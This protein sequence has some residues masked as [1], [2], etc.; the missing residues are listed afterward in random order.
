MALNT[1][2][3]PERVQVF[4][5]PLGV[6]Q[7]PGAA[8]SICAFLIS[9]SA[10]GAPVNV[11]TRVTDMA[12]FEDAFGTADDVLYDGYYAVKGYFDNGGTGKTAVIVN[13][14]T[15]PTA[16]SFI[17][18]AS[19]GTGLRA[20]DSQDDIGLV[21]APGLPLSMAY[22]VQPAVIDYSETVRTEFGASLSTVFSLLSVPKEITKANT[23]T[24]VVAAS[25]LA[26]SA[27][28]G[29]VVSLDA[30]DLSNVTPG[31]VV[32]KASTRIATI[33]AVNDSLNTLTLTSVTGLADDDNITVEMPSAVVYKEGVINNPSK[34]AAWYFNPPL[35]PDLSSTASPGDLVTIDPVG[36]IAGIMG[37]IDANIAIGGISHAPAGIQYAGLAGISGLSLTLSERTDAE[38][39]RLNFINRLQSFPGAGNVVF[40]GYTADSGTS[41][42][43]TADEQLIQVMRTVQYIKA[44][45]EPGLRSFLWENFSPDTQTQVERAIEAFLTNNIH[46]FPAGLPQAQQFRVLRV[47][48]TQ[49]DLDLGLLKVRVLV[50]PNKAVRFIEVSLEFPLQS[51]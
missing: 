3:G 19:T 29:L 44:S 40:G 9:T 22:L 6:V 38:P 43:F 1:N 17:G 33:T 2:I 48:A 15:S 27:I 20:L 21:C 35:V 28:S 50:K 49:Q 39:L 16:N 34:V 31:M 25:L 13:V 4:P 7:V 51:A 30:V 45:L 32:Y 42:L 11:P 8:T 24:T 23:R 14:G 36:H 10:S 46:L 5:T 47:E 41:P 12:G 26:S 18:N 37:R